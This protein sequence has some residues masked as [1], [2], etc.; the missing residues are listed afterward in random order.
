MLRG[1]AYT[2]I[3]YLYTLTLNLH[4]N[5]FKSTTTLIPTLTPTLIPTTM[6]P[7]EKEWATMA[8]KYRYGIDADKAS[9]DKLVKFIQTTI[10]LYK[11]QDLTDNNL[12]TVF[13][14]QFKGF[15]V[16]SFKKIYS[17]IKSK[18]QRHLLK[19]GVYVGRY[20]SR[21]TIS[22]LLFEVL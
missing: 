17:D 13:Q 10:Y 9:K 8:S 20:N 3:P 5:L 22:K 18:L 12:W 7:T 6:A 11:T 2:L 4:P 1:H 14:E 16:E 19:R 15:T 21:V